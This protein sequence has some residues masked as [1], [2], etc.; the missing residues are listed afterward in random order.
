VV[1]EVRAATEV[2]ILVLDASRRGARIG[3]GSP[4]EP[5]IAVRAGPCPALG[6]ES[7]LAFAGGFF[8]DEPACVEI[9]VSVGARVE[10]AR[11]PVGV[12]C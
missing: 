3:W 9:Q 7:W 2:E 11:V 4:A 5:S 12:A 10:T 8:V 1:R 6:D